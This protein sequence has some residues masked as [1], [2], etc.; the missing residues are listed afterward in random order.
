M[1][2]TNVD[3]SRLHADSYMYV[4]FVSQNRPTLF[5]IHIYL[6]TYFPRTHTA[7][8]FWKNHVQ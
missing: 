6:L 5:P 8:Q 1:A 3:D 4:C 2:V 7:I